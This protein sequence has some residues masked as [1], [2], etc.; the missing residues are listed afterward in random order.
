MTTEDGRATAPIGAAIHERVRTVTAP[1]GLRAVL[2]GGHRPRPS[3]SGLHFGIAFAVLALAASVAVLGGTRGTAHAPSLAAAAEHA[4][5]ASTLPPPASRTDGFLKFGSGRVRFPAYR[6]PA[7]W[8]PS[9]ARDERL[10]GRNAVSVQYA[11]GGVR[12]GY[13]IIDGAPL[14][15]PTGARQLVYEGV[16][17]AV[18]ERAGLR[19][20]TWQRGGRTCL[21]A[22]RGATL[23]RL[24]EMTSARG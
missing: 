6:A 16:R 15:A 1:E 18:V 22:T 17:V 14:V 21:L 9:G 23:A 19:I 4:L 13:G 5:R 2:R 3:R 11:R 24:L 8:Q 20:V 12:V 7:T 10:G